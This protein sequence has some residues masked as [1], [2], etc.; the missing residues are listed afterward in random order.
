MLTSS[1][2]HLYLLGAW[3]LV[4]LAYGQPCTYTIKGVVNDQST[5]TPLADAYIV[6]EEAN[7]ETFSDE[8][9][10]FIIN[11]VC[12]GDY[13]LNI[14]HMACSSK[15][16]YIHLHKDTTIYIYMDHHSELISEVHVHGDLIKDKTQTSVTV[17]KSGILDATGK[18]LSQTIENIAGVSTLT[19]GSGIAKPVIQ[20][21]WG[22]RIS[23]INNGIAQSG[24]QWGIDHS[25][26]IDPFVANHI[27]V[28]KGASALAYGGVSLGGV[29]LV[30]PAPIAHEPHIHGLINYNFQSNGLGNTLNAQAE[31]WKP[32][33]AWR[34][35][36]TLKVFGDRKSPN[37]F[38]TNTGN[39]EANIAATFQKDFG[40]RFKTSVYYSLFNTEIGILRGSHISNST[41]LE[42]AF[43]RN[44]PFFTN[45][46]FS[47]NITAP[48]QRVQHH[49]LKAEAKYLID[50]VQSISLL[51]GGQLNNRNEYD[52][53]RAGRSD[54]PALSLAQITHFLEGVY[55][56]NV[57]KNWLLKTGAQFN[58]VDNTNDNANTD[59]M[60]LIPD[61]RSYQ[62]SV[63]AIS[64]LTLNKW[65][66]EFGARID[67]R[68]LEALTISQTFPREI[69]R[70][71]K[72]FANYNIT[73]GVQY[74]WQ[75]GLDVKM[76]VG[77]VQRQPEV[78][79]LYSS[80][81]HQ[82]LASVEYG[83]PNLVAENSLKTVVAFTFQPAKPWNAQIA[84]YY[85]VINDY[86]FLKPT[87]EYELNISGS[88]PIFIYDQTDARLFGADM[89]LTYEI[90]KH[91]KT[92][93]IASFLQGDD[94]RNN[95][96][97]IY[98]PA[99][100]GLLR[101]TYAFTNNSKWQNSSIG[102]QGKV[103]LKQNHLNANQDFMPPPNGYVLVGVQAT[104]SRYLRYNSLDFSLRIENALNTVYRDYLN[105]LRYFADDMGINISVRVGYNF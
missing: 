91:L 49:L 86:I 83:N 38:L 3:L 43:S 50:D 37:Y 92:T 76:D 69:S 54:K 2:H 42:A 48:R 82:G 90:S 22:N 13:H 94:L 98:M 44:E 64:S 101:L 73:A 11:Q 103:V 28:I 52:V 61:Y 104:T 55:T 74:Q 5:Q 16:I 47:Y 35:S 27:T 71:N 19:N 17:E 14:A 77:Y 80:G 57:Y 100:N 87:G 53:R 7:L 81:L 89:L 41:D 84:T 65:F 21:M 62:G 33:G 12:A 29:V 10:N 4:V 56:A 58:Y 102:I 34:L 45:D 26:E 88:F 25:P 32:W 18:N 20:G 93:F 15:R 63:F 39:K 67:Y 23:I 59:R 97:L 99:N 36:G 95:V 78:N 60:P 79:E 68:Q 40:N 70:Q 30:D 31:Q 72:Q 75:P 66:L 85:H 96:P 46:Y 51:Y 105:R 9:G 6:L 24:Q 1:K 8:A